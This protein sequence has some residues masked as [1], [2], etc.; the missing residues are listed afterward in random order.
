[1]P[2]KYAKTLLILALGLL[3][4]IPLLW[5]AQHPKVKESFPFL[6]SSVAQVSRRPAWRA[7]KTYQSLDSIHIKTNEEVR[8]VVEFKNTG[9]NTW[10]RGGKD[11]FIAVNNIKPENRD[12]PFQAPN[13]EYKYDSRTWR[14]GRMDTPRVLPGQTGRFYITLQAPDQPGQYTERFQL[15]SEYRA[16]IPG[17]EFS[18]PITVDPYPGPKNIRKRGPMIRV[19]ILETDK[20]VQISA[21]GPYEVRSQRGNLIAL[22][23]KNE[24]VRARFARGNY[25]LRGPQT[26]SFGRYRPYGWAHRQ[27]DLIRFHAKGDTIIQITNFEDRPGWNPALNDNRF[28][29]ILE[30]R[31]LGPNRLMVINILPMEHYL[32]GI[33]EVSDYAHPQLQKSLAVASRT[34]A[35]YITRVAPK[36]RGRPYQ[37]TNTTSDQVYKGYALEL[38]SPRLS[39]S[40]NQTAGQMVTY[41]NKVVLTPYFSQSDGRTRSSK[42]VWGGDYPWLQSVPDPFCR[43]KELRGHG[44]GLSGTGASIAAS[45]YG[46]RYSEILRYYYRGTSLKNIY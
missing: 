12:S 35:Y 13:W 20:P 24:N 36:Y 37:I 30:I 15:V 11:A 6:A 23:G 16:Y 17:G 40:V 41:Q 38:R 31:R 14:P 8:L 7:Q 21:N 43:G 5:L 33:A 39:R 1:M 25:I 42:E 46:K 19:K 18:I 22:Y 28:R 44:V 27:R 10:R 3:L 32:H 26:N 2:Q 29:G 34:Y 9:R 4:L 45:Q